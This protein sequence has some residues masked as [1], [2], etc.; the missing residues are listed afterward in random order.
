MNAP[1][2]KVVPHVRPEW[3]GRAQ[4]LARE[5]APYSS[6]YKNQGAP[7]VVPSRVVLRQLGG[8][9]SAAAMAK[10]ATTCVIPHMP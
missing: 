10:E 6:G 2:K 8:P 5:S 4:I 1:R 7:R 9:R 3:N